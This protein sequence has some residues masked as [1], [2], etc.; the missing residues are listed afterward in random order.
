MNFVSAFANKKVYQDRYPVHLRT[1]FATFYSNTLISAIRAS[2][3]F[4]P[5][6][7]NLRVGYRTKGLNDG[8]SS[9]FDRT[10]EPG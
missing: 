3:D 4:F 7:A 8:L 10:E 6:R 5:L 1:F 2:Y 9:D